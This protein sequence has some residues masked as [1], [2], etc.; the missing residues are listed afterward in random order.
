VK[1]KMIFYD[2]EKN[3]SLNRINVLEEQ[4]EK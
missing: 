4:A 3:G 2:A 1:K